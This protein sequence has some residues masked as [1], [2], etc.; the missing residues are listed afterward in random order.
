[1]SSGNS[2]PLNVPLEAS[3][4]ASTF[5]LYR[6]TSASLVKLAA[7]QPDN[8]SWHEALG[9]CYTDGAPRQ[10]FKAAVAEF[11]AAIAL[12]PADGPASLQS[13]ARLLAGKGLQSFTLSLD[14]RRK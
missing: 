13:R 1:M 5:N 3:N 7:L 11:S 12:T 14:L 9:Q 10:D 2:P 8:P 4:F 6:Y